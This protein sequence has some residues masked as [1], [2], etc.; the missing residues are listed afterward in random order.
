ME[1]CGARIATLAIAGSPAFAGDDSSEL[2]EDAIPERSSRRA[3]LETARR[4]GY[5]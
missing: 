4:I 1:S 3:A 2:F 5:A